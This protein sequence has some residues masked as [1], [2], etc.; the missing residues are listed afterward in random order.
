MKKVIIGIHGLGNKPPKYLLSKWWENAILEGF[1]SQGIKKKLPKFELAYWADILHD[2]PLNYW[3]KETKSPYYLDE[4]Y[5]KASKNFILEDHYFRLKVVDFVSNQLNRIFLNDDKTINYSFITDF[6]LRKYFSDLDVYYKEECKD[7]FDVTCKA[8]D[9]IRK[10]IGETI[11]KYSHYEIM[12]IAHSMGS[13]ISLD[14]L[15]FLISDVKI[16]TLVTIGSPLGLPLVVGKMADEQKIRLNG[17]SILATPP[18]VTNKWYNLADI[19]DKVALN[20]KLADDFIPNNA[21]VAPEDFLVINNF[22]SDGVKNPHKSY[23]YLRTP[24]F[25]KILSDFIGDEKMNLVQKV[26]VYLLKLVGKMNMRLSASTQPGPIKI[27]ILWG[28]SQAHS[29]KNVCNYCVLK[30]WKATYSAK[31]TKE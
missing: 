21:G 30:R 22:E 26:K 2:K 6:I 9:L 17:K 14:V 28:R 12:I 8:K 29:G 10:R 15:N 31:A 27:R 25:S 7:E 20:Y 16:N 23:G 3:E 4:P 24:E 1:N 11:K 5:I 19:M 18:G 13:I